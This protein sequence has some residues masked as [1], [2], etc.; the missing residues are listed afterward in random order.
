MGCDTVRSGK[1]VDVSEESTA[2]IF[3][4]ITYQTT[5]RHISLMEQKLS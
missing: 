1:I 2:S 5:Q 4:V 3:R